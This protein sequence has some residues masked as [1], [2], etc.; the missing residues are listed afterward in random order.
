VIISPT[1]TSLIK[2][3]GSLK[4]M[5]G[6]FIVLVIL[7][8]GLLAPLIAPYDPGKS[9]GPPLTPPSSK[10]LMGTD[11]LGFDV[12]SRIVWGSRVVFQVV[13]SATL[14]ALIIGVVLGVISGFYGGFLDRILSMIM[15]SLYAFPSL[16]LA[17]A[18]AA[19]LGPSPY[20]AAIAIATVYIPTYYRMVRG[21]TLAIRSQL[22]V[23]AAIAAGLRDRT[24]MLSYILPNL[25]YT[26]L[27]ILPLNIA[28]AILTEAGLSFLGLTVSPP[29][30]DWGFDLRIG[31]RFLLSGYWWLSVFPGLA[32]MAL[33]L[34]FALIGEGLSDRLQLRGLR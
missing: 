6:L 27:V 34:G 4:I 18:I 31:Q 30:P 9:A 14:L 22:Y 21:Q 12:F 29:T 25:T 28:D 24:I 8:T 13:V 20:N 10:H 19:V 11:H 15:D 26:I 33:A 7:L 5:V 3:P 2:L 23:E 17:I 32:I 1:I 16:I